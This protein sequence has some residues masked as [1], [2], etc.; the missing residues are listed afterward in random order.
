MPGACRLGDLGSHGGVIVTASDT[1]ARAD[2]IP[3]AR[4]GDTYACALHGP[5]PLATGSPTVNDGG[6]PVVRLGDLA[7]CGAVMVSASTTVILDEGGGA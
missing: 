3:I 2:G 4:I 5:V 1:V 7:S 6:K